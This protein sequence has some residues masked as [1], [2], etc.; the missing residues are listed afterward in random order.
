[1]AGMNELPSG[2]QSVRRMDTMTGGCRVV[3]GG[4]GWHIG[5]THIPESYIFHSN[6]QRLFPTEILVVC[7]QQ[8]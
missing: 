7:R 3:W 2:F 4:S 6:T 5:A 8:K 1:M